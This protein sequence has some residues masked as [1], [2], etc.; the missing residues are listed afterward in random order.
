VEIRI[1][2]QVGVARLHAESLAVGVE[3]PDDR[4]A[5]DLYT[6]GMS[7]SPRGEHD[8][9][10]IGWRKRIGATFDLGLVVGGFWAVASGQEIGEVDGSWSPATG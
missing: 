4:A 7:R 6:F 3:H 10:D 5:D 9:A 8:G 2:Q 1:N